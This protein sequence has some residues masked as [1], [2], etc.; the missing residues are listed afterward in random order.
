MQTFIEKSIEQIITKSLPTPSTY[1]ILP[2]RRARKKWQEKYSENRKAEL[3]PRI[4]AI[5]DFLE[6]L[7]DIVIADQVTLLL[8]LYQVY[9]KIFQENTENIQTFI[10]FGNTLIQDFN[11]IDLNIPKDKIQNFFEYLTASKAIERWGGNYITNSKQKKQVYQYFNYWEKLQI[12]YIN[13]KKELEKKNIGYRGL[14]YQKLNKKLSITYIEKQKIDRI[15]FIGLNQLSLSEVL[16]IKKL[17]KQI[18][19]EFYWDIDDYLLENDQ[20]EAGIHI[21]KSIKKLPNAYHKTITS[22][23]SKR[24]QTIKLIETNSNIH[25]VKTIG[26]IITNRLEEIK[27]KSENLE[28]FSKKLKT[29]I[30][31]L[32]NETLLLPLL[33]SFSSGKYFNKPINYFLNITMGIPL[34]Q[35]ATFNYLTQLLNLIN[36]KIIQKRETKILTSKIQA[37]FSHQFIQKETQ[38]KADELF[39]NAPAYTTID[40]QLKSSFLQDET[41]Q[42]SLGLIEKDDELLIKT[43]EVLETIIEKQHKT[44]TLEYQSLIETYKTIKSLDQKLNKIQQKI[45]TKALIELTLKILKTTSV[46]LVGDPKQK[47]QIMGMLEARSLDFEEVYIL[48]ANEGTL[49]SKKQIETTIPYDIALNF[50]LP[51]YYDRDASTAYNFYRIIQRSEKITIT[52]TDPFTSENGKEKSRYILQI[53][54]ELPNNTNKTIIEKR[55]TSKINISSIPVQK[56]KKTENLISKI[57]KQLEYGISP[58]AINLYTRNPIDFFLKY[59]INVNQSEERQETINNKDF[60]TVIHEALDKIYDNFTEKWITQEHIA[61]INNTNR[62]ENLVR[63]TIESNINGLSFEKG[64]NEISL[65]IITKLL[66]NYLQVIKK[67]A[68]YYIISKEK[69]YNATIPMQIDE[70]GEIKFKIIGKADLVD[71]ANGN[72]RVVDYKTGKFDKPSLKAENLEEILTNYKKEKIV[73]LLT[74]KYLIYKQIQIDKIKLPDKNPN[75]NVIPGFYFFR[76][77]KEE[78][79]Q[80][81]IKEE[82][83]KPLEFQAFAETFYLTFASQIL[84][85][86]NLLVET[87]Y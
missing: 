45:E 56:I 50:G 55:L 83:S 19:T 18:P 63:E 28:D 76:A 10:Y 15:C 4:L 86:D 49:P 25:Q 61:E 38:A 11:R 26:Q 48:S 80:Y 41:V 66:Q 16:I 75:A 23:F 20:Q 59:I 62:L 72:I 58:S 64:R 43:L 6:N 31:I 42:K 53:K 46:S 52:Y 74:Y 44:N 77:L 1:I 87:I 68:P 14:L 82:P 84:N 79:Q 9:K 57:K 65:E 40:N 36:N 17:N 29:T 39:N 71:Y 81:Q 13:Y 67:N 32:P 51:T 3:L 70:I 2:T 35:T 5:S 47:I 85:P 30:I 73:Q 34:S 7:S 37:L 54:E 33:N 22:N 69:T 24:K 60:G 12:V 78:F 8:E 27:E 21:K